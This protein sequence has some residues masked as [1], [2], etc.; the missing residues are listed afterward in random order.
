MRFRVIFSQGHRSLHHGQGIIAST[1]QFEDRTQHFP[2]KTMERKDVCQ[3]LGKLTR[4]RV[5]ALIDQGRKFLLLF[6]ARRTLSTKKE[7]IRA[8]R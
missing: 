6:A 7:G 1:R 5:P 8:C 4:L 2:S 3:L